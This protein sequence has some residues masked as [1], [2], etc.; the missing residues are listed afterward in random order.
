MNLKS[1]YYISS[2]FWGALSKTINAIIKFVTIPLLLAYFGKEHYGILTLVIATNAYMGLMDL[3]MSTGA[4]K[5]FSQWIGEKRM[6]LLDSVCRTSITFYGII[7]CLNAIILLLIGIY[8]NLL[9]NLS[10]NDFEL[11]RKCLF[12]LSAFTIIN[13]SSFSLSQILTANEN[14]AF[15]QQT[16]TVKTILSLLIVIATITF[17]ASLIHYFFL[18]LLS[19]TIM[20]LPLCYKVKQQKLLKS[21]IP[22]TD[23]KHFKIILTYSLS[24]FAMGVFQLTATQSRPLVLGIFSTG[25][26]GILSEY[27]I[28]EVFPLFIISIGGL[29][30][31]MLLPKSSRLILTGDQEAIN[32]Y[33]EKGTQYTSIL[34]ALMC[35]PIALNSKELLTIYVGSEYGYLSKW[36]TMWI[37]TIVLYQHLSPVSSLILAT[38]KTKMLVYSSAISCVISILINAVLCKYY[39]VG[40]AVIGYFTY[41]LIYVFFIYFYFNRYV[42]HLNSLRIFKNFILPTVIGVVI[43]III[44]FVN[45]NYFNCYVHI[46]VK[47][48]T[49]IIL[50]AATIHFSKI[51][52]LNL[53][54][55]RK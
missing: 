54:F 12:T 14:M 19:Q 8:G 47:S 11:F 5:Y 15:I 20:I 35:F 48:A 31:T 22:Q 44:N 6:D 36:L 7:G 10:T 18:L 52:P 45:W 51:M 39:G 16:D 50:F 17:G 28:L 41:I 53:L 26:V 29:I 42:L 1:N 33:M 38:G 2:F 4:V 32:N 23:W 27:R 37:M 21:F 55:K 30:I 49:W 46:I 24:I 25:G 43:G 13:W 3:G 9:F 34:T 40:S